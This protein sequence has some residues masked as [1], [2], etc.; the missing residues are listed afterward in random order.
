MNDYAL[1]ADEATQTITLHTA[2][3]PAAR[4]AADAGVMVMTMLGCES[5]PDDPKLL[6]HDC[7]RHKADAPVTPANV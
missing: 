3:C 1:V 6:R 4:A 2:T 7:L 5:E